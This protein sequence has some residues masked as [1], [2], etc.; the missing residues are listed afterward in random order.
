M[1]LNGYPYL[2]AEYLDG[3]NFR[4]IDRSRIR[5]DVVVTNPDPNR[6]VV[7]IDIDD[8]GMP[9]GNRTM[10]NVFLET[11]S[12]KARNIG[13]FDVI[14]SGIIAQIEYRIENPQ[15]GQLIRSMT[16][17][18]HIRDRNY[19]MAV[20]NR[21][22][23]NNAVVMNF[24]DS[25]VVTNHAA[26][27]GGGSVMMRI[28]RIRLFYQA[29]RREGESFNDHRSLDRL[30]PVRLPN[31]DSRM[32]IGR[33]HKLHQSQ[34]I[35]GD[36]GAIHRR[37]DHFTNPPQWAAFNEFY[38]FNDFGRSA[39]LHHDIINDANTPTYVI[40]CGEIRM[41][42]V[43]YIGASHRVHFKLNIWKNDLVVV[44]NTRR[45]V[46]ML[47]IRFFNTFRPSPS[48][49]V[50]GILRDLLKAINDESLNLNLTDDQVKELTRLVHQILGKRPPQP[51]P[52]KS[53][54]INELVDLLNQLVNGGDVDITDPVPGDPDPD[55]PPPDDNYPPDCDAQYQDPGNVYVP[56]GNDD[57]YPHPD[58]DYIDPNIPTDPPDYPPDDDYDD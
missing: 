7:D 34:M 36:D 20:N 30:N 51:K 10:W 29:V 54:K 22:I 40:P 57:Y 3:V 8:V 55:D 43:F 26:I 27:P 47:G 35:M 1:N 12:R 9:T 2:L 42:R 4:Q 33:H 32:G 18:I 52:K 39:I 38:H 11:L 45:I 15:T 37:P 48:N 31:V 23:D 50:N 44:N 6:T 17:R 25:S 19:F 41:E 58:D 13:H 28:T 5:N 53:S 16:E 56:P 24:N 14:R 46:D 49:N 21:D